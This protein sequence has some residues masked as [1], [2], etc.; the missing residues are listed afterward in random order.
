MSANGRI[1]PGDELKTYLVELTGSWADRGIRPENVEV[2]LRIDPQA[3]TGN[4]IETLDT[5]FNMG[6]TQVRWGTG[7][8]TRPDSQVSVDRSQP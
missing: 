8:V 6:I 4:V 2:D 7:Q 3:S 1:I 5:F